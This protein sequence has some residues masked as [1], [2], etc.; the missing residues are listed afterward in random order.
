MKQ[1]GNRYMNIVAISIDIAKGDDTS[2][3]KMLKKIISREMRQRRYK[4][5]Q[6]LI[7]TSTGDS[8]R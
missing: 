4:K 7:C 6:E 1:L 2:R 8:L 3:S 5:C